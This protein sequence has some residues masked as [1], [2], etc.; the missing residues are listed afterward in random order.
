MSPLQPPAGPGWHLEGGTRPVVTFE[1]IT[2]VTCRPELGEDLLV[3]PVRIRSRHPPGDRTWLVCQRRSRCNTEGDTVGGQAGIQPG[4]GEHTAS[5]CLQSQTRSMTVEPSPGCIEYLFGYWVEEDG[6]V[7]YQGC[8][9]RLGR[10]DD[11]TRAGD[12][13]CAPRTP[14]RV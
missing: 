4:E 1:R 10:P 11:I 3:H 7:T 14:A 9:N 8:V 2:V 6:K 12:L 5:A 13:L